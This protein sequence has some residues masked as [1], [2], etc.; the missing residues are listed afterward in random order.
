MSLR[1]EP[2]KQQQASVQMRMVQPIA[3]VRSL[4]HV[5]RCVPPCLPPGPLSAAA[6]WGRLSLLCLPSAYSPQGASVSWEVDGQELADTGASQSSVEQQK[7]GLYSSSS[8]LSLSEG[9]WLQG[10]LFSCRVHHHGH[11]QV[12][13]S[14]VE[15]N[16]AEIFVRPLH[17]FVSLWYTFGGGTQLIVDLGVQRPT[18]TVLPPSRGELQMGSATVLCVASGGFPSDWTLGWKV[19][20]ASTERSH[21]S[22]VMRGDGLYS[23]ISVLK[24]STER[25]RDASVSCEAHR[26]G[27]SPVTESLEPLSCSQ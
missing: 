8:V 24:L 11:T 5:V 16:R 26:S 25:W 4:T 2:V 21:S 12:R 13:E 3:M 22:V 1:L 18:L 20:G 19:G 17:D 23:H 7:S 27:Q 15:Q 9:S 14:C 6:L 10:Q